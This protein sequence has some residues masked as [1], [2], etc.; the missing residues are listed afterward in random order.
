M[1]HH[2]LSRKKVNRE[3]YSREQM[4]Q[5]RGEGE[6]E[7]EGTEK[8]L[9]AMVGASFDQSS[10]RGRTN[11]NVKFLDGQEQQGS[12]ARSAS[13]ANAVGSYILNSALCQERGHFLCRSAVTHCTIVFCEG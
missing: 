6:R 11:L 12:A 9:L 2:F 13:L 5:R 1:K 10:L 8:L 3:S 4:E 7:G